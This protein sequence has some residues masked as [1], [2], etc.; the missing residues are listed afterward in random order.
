LAYKALKNPIKGTVIDCIV[1]NPNYKDNRE[2]IADIL[3]LLLA[4]HDTT[5]YSIA[6][7]LL[8]VAKNQCEQEKLLKDLSAKSMEEPYVS[9][10]L[11]AQCD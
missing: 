8:E 3:I 11:L 10:A 4:G 6:W 1:N 2:R 7:I 5:D 9:K